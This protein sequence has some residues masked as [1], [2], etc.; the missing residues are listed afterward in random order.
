MTSPFLLARKL[1]DEQATARLA[2]DLAMV[3]APGDVIALEGDLGAGKTTF[4]RALLR[5][6]ADDAGLEV[7]SPTFTLA[8]SYDDLRV[9]VT[10][11]DLYRLGSSDELEEI[12]FSEALET[13]AALIEWPERADG[14]LPADTLVLRLDTT[15]SPDTREATLS[16]ATGAGAAKWA[17]RLRR[18]F[19][20]RAFLDS[21]GWQGAARRHLQGDA[22]TRSY[23]RIHRADTTAVLMNAPRQPDGP[24]IED[25]KPYSQIAHLAEDVR[26]FVA[27]GEALRAHGFSAP[28][29]LAH[30]MAAGILLLEDLGGEGVVADGAPIADRYAVATDL[31][32]NLHGTA[33]PAEA[34]L[35]DGTV[36]RVPPYDRAALSI[37]VRLLLDWYV[38]HV[39]GGPIGDDARAAFLDAWSALFDI[40]ARAETTWV[41]R[42]FHSPNLIWLAERQGIARIGLI[43]YQDALIGPTAYDLASLLQDA[44]VTV[45]AA[46]EAELY[47][48]YCT[49]RRTA[50]AGFDADAFAAAYA[51]MAAQRAT[52]VLGIFARLNARDGKP[53]YLAHIPRIRDYLTRSLAHPVLSDLK[54]WYETHLP[55]P[56]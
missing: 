18:S 42:D 24:P 16:T 27:I 9:P 34:P 35:P 15:P 23:E 31:L 53:A 40:L 32:A 44:R 30:D 45:P 46:L 10:H 29:L 5:A 3:L 8:Q 37:E 7:P 22:S 43:D 38:P 21:S 33:L 6:L 25:G 48:A 19:T 28:D 52:K 54:L 49:A 11:F 39:T 56:L 14:F 26:P 17:A 55:V 47:A 1:D 51:I 41:L 12:G 50:D 2:E 4:A 13:G 20:I 36:H